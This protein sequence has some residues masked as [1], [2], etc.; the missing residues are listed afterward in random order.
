MRIIW[1]L[2]A[3]GLATA[4]QARAPSDS[5][6]EFIAAEMQNSGVPGIAL[7]IVED[8]EIVTGAYGEALIGSGRAVTPSTPFLIGS[9]SKSIT[10]MAVMQLVESEA[11]DLDAP[12]STYL[13]EFQENASGAITTRQLLS[14]TSGFSTRQ[15]NDIHDDGA[16][17]ANALQRQVERIALWS[18]THAPDE[19][20]QYSNANYLVL[21]ALVEAVSGR[22]FASYVE[23]E[24]LEPIGMDDTFVADGRS[25]EAM[26]IGHQPWFGTKRALRNNETSRAAAPAGGVVSTASDLAL[27]LAVMMNGQD[28][29]ISAESKS[30]MLRPASAASPG[31]GFG[32]GIDAARGA[33]YHSG[34]TPGVETLAVMLPA[35]GRGVVMLANAN[36]GM[37][38]GENVRLFNGVSARVLGLDDR[39]DESSWGRKV[40][41]LTFA[42]LPVIFVAA[43]LAVWLQRRGLRAKSGAFGAFTLWFPLLATLAVAWTA[44]QLIPQLFG[45]SLEAFSR[46]QPDFA[47]LLV[48][49]AATGVLWAVFRL[50]TFYVGRHASRAPPA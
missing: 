32:W 46:Y 37:G 30:V 38:F 31:Y 43:I 14:H 18:P 29:V 42:L 21:G 1:A 40:L 9:I 23:S 6:S 17:S 33:A 45:V 27:F 4:A 3:V 26:A 22:A 13:D 7:A 39:G 35:E 5:L 20:W 25:D 2:L 44:L 16:H 11:V 49:T 12:I 48:A 19:R 10:A 24:I 15:G 50:A 8:G 47:L 34:L 36:G 28:D 41:F